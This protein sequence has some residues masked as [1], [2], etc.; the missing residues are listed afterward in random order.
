MY[1]RRE[2]RSKGRAVL[3]PLQPTL[4]PDHGHEIVAIDQ[5]SGEY[6]LGA[7]NH[8]ALDLFRAKFSGRIAYLV[9]VDG[10]PIIRYLA[11]TSDT[12]V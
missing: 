3:E 8:E 6:A 9:R 7:T 2:F 12:C 10:G 5:N 1:N 11:R 4:L